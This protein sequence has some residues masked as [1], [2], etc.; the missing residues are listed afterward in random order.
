MPM[1]NGEWPE[2][3]L[4]QPK[5]PLMLTHKK[6]LAEKLFAHRIKSKKNSVF[7]SLQYGFETSIHCVFF[8]ITIL[9]FGNDW[10]I[11]ALL[12][13]LKPQNAALKKSFFVKV[14]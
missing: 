10:L 1:L 6:L 11:L 8:S 4:K 5:F 12:Q 13:T 9:K 7:I 14:S 3:Q 2:K